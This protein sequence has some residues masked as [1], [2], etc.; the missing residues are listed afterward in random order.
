MIILSNLFKCS[1]HAP[2]LGVCVYLWFASAS[3]YCLRLCLHAGPVYVYARLFEC[4][5]RRRQWSGEG[6]AMVRQWSGNGRATVGQ[7]SGHV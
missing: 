1:A 6:R 7:W 3:T 4:E 5:T 2:T